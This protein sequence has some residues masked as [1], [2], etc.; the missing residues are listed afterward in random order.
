MPA[1][2]M[3]ECCVC[4]EDNVLSNK[5]TRCGHSVCQECLKK[6]PRAVCPMCRAE[7]QVPPKSVS[8]EE[9]VRQTSGGWTPQEHAAAIMRGSIEEQDMFYGYLSTPLVEAPDY[10]RRNSGY[11]PEYGAKWCAERNVAHDETIAHMLAVG[12]VLPNERL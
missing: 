2:S 1:V 10:V 8:R 9:P 11:T 12:Y 6:L 3:L 5:K 4:L 7:I